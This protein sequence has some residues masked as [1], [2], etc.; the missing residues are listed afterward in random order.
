MPPVKIV[1]NNGQII[2]HKSFNTQYLLWLFN[3]EGTTELFKLFL[4]T[5]EEKVITNFVT[6]YNLNQSKE[7]DIIEKLKE[8]INYI[9]EIYDISH[10]KEIFD[11]NNE[12]LD[13]NGIIGKKDD[14]NTNLESF[15][16]EVSFS[17]N[18]FNLKFEFI[19]KK[20]FK[21]FPYDND[22]FY[23]LGDN[24]SNEFFK[25]SEENE[26]KNEKIEFDDVCI[27]QLTTSYY[28]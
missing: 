24:I 25:K 17:N 7:P 14:N 20:Q 10:K 5:E 4:K 9:P 22:N 21:E 1:L 23:Y 3:Q 11:G 26:I 18:P 2:Q 16:S 15:D 8:Y 27:R 19:E 28:K 12:L 13:T 6:E